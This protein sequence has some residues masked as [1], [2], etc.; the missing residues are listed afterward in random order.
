MV[1]GGMGNAVCMSRLTGVSGAMSEAGPARRRWVGAVALIATL[2]VATAA[3][4]DDHAAAAGPLPFREVSQGARGFEMPGESMLAR[5]RVARSASQAA[6]ALRAWGLDPT[7]TKSVNFARESAIVVLAPYQPTGG[8]RARVSQVLVRGREAA[9]TGSVRYEGGETAAAS[10][11]RPWVVIT[12][13]RAS[14]SRVRD[15]RIKLR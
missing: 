11:E 2:A 1:P 14:L 7:A 6:K 4:T 10:I 15:V 8:Y 3:S 9:L 5:G 12:V 13:K